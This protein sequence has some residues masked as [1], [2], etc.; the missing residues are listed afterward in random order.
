MKEAAAK[1]M[2]S[3]KTVEA[4]IYN[5]RRKTG[6]RRIN[7]LLLGALREG[8]LSLEDFPPT[9]SGALALKQRRIGAAAA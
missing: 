2:L 1:L 8:L 6:H 3:P 4:H 5:M 9:P 7:D